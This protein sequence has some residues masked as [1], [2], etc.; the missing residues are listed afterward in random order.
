M[1]VYLKCYVLLDVI[2][3][4][5]VL[6]TLLYDLWVAPHGCSCAGG[7]ARYQSASLLSHSGILRLR[8]PSL[9]AQGY[10]QSPY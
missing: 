7:V 3:M 4:Y 9:A 1:Y 5:V 2:N 10:A 8:I 6:Q